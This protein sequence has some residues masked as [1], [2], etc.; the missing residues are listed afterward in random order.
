MN[1][2]ERGFLLNLHTVE[3]EKM[4][5]KQDTKQHNQTN[6]GILADI[7]DALRK[8]AAIR[9]LDLGSLSIKVE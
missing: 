9:S 5:S 6:D 4:S 7:W 2:Y 1:S 8:Q 3:V